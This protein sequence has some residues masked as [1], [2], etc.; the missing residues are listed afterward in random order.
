MGAARA[1]QPSS[2]RCTRIP[3]CFLLL[4]FACIHPAAGHQVQS[5]GRCLCPCSKERP[6]I[7]GARKV[8]LSL[9]K[10]WHLAFYY[11]S[12]GDPIPH[13]MPWRES[14]ARGRSSSEAVCSS[15]GLWSQLSRS[16][17]QCSGVSCV[18]TPASALFIFVKHETSSIQS[19]SWGDPLRKCRGSTV[20]DTAVQWPQSHTCA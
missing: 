3:W 16:R 19:S 13:G 2:R 18:L 11:A 20:V 12:K 9:V 8:R 7:A 17:V 6:V 15:S 4:A 1:W 10:T 14:Y 5:A